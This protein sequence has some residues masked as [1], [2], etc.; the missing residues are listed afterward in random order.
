MVDAQLLYNF[1]TLHLG[2]KKG[3]WF[4]SDPICHM[5][6]YRGV[7]EMTHINKIEEKM[8]RP[9][10]LIHGSTPPPFSATNYN[11]GIVVIPHLSKL[12][13]GITTMF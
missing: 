9:R 2:Y 10:E 8:E 12:L 5:S 13:N 6:S 4:K 11:S 3:G 1:L 7:G